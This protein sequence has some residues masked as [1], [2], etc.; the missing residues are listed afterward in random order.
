MYN[1]FMPFF[2]CLLAPIAIQIIWLSNI[3]PMSVRSYMISD[4]ETFIECYSWKV[5][6]YQGAHWVLKLGVQ[7]RW[8]GYNCCFFLNF[9][10]LHIE[11]PY[12]FGGTWPILV[13]KK[14]SA[15][16][17]WACWACSKVYRIQPYEIMFVL[18]SVLHYDD[19]FLQELRFVLQILFAC[20]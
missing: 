17:K 6:S 5:S 1:V 13:F 11:S 18:V 8:M 10:P 14:P 3:L 15:E 7:C 20:V 4:H 12:N 2:V 16:G 19:Y 9:V